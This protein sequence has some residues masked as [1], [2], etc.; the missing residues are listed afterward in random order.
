[1]QELEECLEAMLSEI[2]PA[3]RTEYVAITEAVGRVISE[4]IVADMMIPP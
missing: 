3:E 2:Q 1:M 4:D